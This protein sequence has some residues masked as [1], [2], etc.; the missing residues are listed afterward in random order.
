MT[1]HTAQAHGAS[2]SVRVDGSEDKPWLLLANSLATD[3]G[4]WDDQIPFLV[5]THRVVRFDARGHGASEVAEAPYDLATLSD[6]MLAVLDAVGAA[7]A[8]VMGLSLGGMTA[9]GLALAHPERV[10]SLV[11]CCARADAPEPFH[12]SWDDRIAIV[13]D[14]GTEGL[15]EGTLARWFSAGVASTVRDRAATMIRRTSAEGYIGCA[16]AIQGLDHLK[17]LHRMTVPVLYVAGEL[18]LAA[19][20]PAMQAMADATPGSRLIVLPRLAHVPVMEA[21][22]VFAKA[23]DGWRRDV[24]GEA[25]A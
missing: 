22:G 11:V 25:K 20:V 14:R 3:V 18:D 19:P 13:R 10:R 16:R 6:D 17:D 7:R 4:M 9:M 2:L 23:I 21:P 24:Q 1:R 8:D 12:A 15:V 5:R